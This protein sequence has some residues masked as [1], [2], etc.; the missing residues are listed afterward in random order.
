[1]PADREQRLGG[2]AVA[3]VAAEHGEQPAAV[4]KLQIE[5]RMAGIELD[6][7]G[8]ELPRGP[9]NKVDQ[10]LL[11][12]RNR[13]PPHALAS[14]ERHEHFDRP[15]DVDVLD[16]FVAP[17]G[18]QL[19]EPVDMRHH[20]VEH[21]LVGVVGQ[22]PQSATDTRLVEPGQHAVDLGHRGDLLGV[23]RHPPAD[24]RGLLDLA[25]NAL[26]NGVGDDT[27]QRP[28]WSIGNSPT[29]GSIGWRGGASVMRR[30]RNRA[31]E[32]APASERPGAASVAGDRDHAS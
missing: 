6:F 11:V 27:H 1:M 19:A 17:E 24:V 30:T 31:S 18:I 32:R 3:G 15:V 28:S 23:P 8:S 13:C 5:L 7:V 12:C 9:A 4:G 26:A 20:G 2:H 29:V 22:R 16:I 25:G 10:L 14:D 21:R